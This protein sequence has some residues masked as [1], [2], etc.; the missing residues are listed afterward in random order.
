ML[1]IV[2]GSGVHSIQ[3][4]KLLEAERERTRKHKEY[5]KILSLPEHQQKLEIIKENP[6]LSVLGNYDA[7]E[8]AIASHLRDYSQAAETHKAASIVEKIGFVYT[9][10]VRLTFDQG[11]RNRHE[12]NITWFVNEKDWI[13]LEEALWDQ[14]FQSSGEICSIGAIILWIPR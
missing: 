13:G 2:K 5:Q 6:F 11:N 14:P 10:K 7:F 3:Q 1:R 4:K 12:N 9:G 8:L